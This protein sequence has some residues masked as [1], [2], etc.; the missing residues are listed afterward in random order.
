M[1]LNVCMI[2]LAN[3]ASRSSFV[4]GQSRAPDNFI[5]PEPREAA[6]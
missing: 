6:P 4:S 5:L 1:D 2:F 3:F